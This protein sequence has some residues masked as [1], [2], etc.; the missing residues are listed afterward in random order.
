M[1]KFKPIT[2]ENIN[3]LPIVDGQLIFD[4]SVKKGIYLDVGNTRIKADGLSEVEI[5]EL[6][7]DK[8]NLYHTTVKEP[9]IMSIVDAYN[10]QIDMS[11][12][13]IDLF[14][15]K[16]IG[17]EVPNLSPAYPHI[18]CEFESGMAIGFDGGPP[19][20][21]F[22]RRIGN[23]LNTTPIDMGGE[24]TKLAGVSS[25]APG[26][27]SPISVSKLLL[28]E[29]TGKII[30]IDTESFADGTAPGLNPPVADF[31]MHMAKATVEEEVEKIID[32]E[33]AWIKAN[34]SSTIIKKYTIPYGTF[35]TTKKII[36]DLDLLNPKYLGASL[37]LVGWTESEWGKQTGLDV[38]VQAPMVS[39][40]GTA[41]YLAYTIA[42][43]TDHYMHSG[44]K[45]PFAIEHPALT[46]QGF[47]GVPLSSYDYTRLYGGLQSHSGEDDTELLVVLRS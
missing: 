4:I 15:G 31:S 42:G 10:E 21:M 6:L 33:D 24:S 45:I 3:Q 5:N 46:D 34:E 39:R 17:E 23:G 38:H 35:I 29:N 40:M 44:V 41:G 9:K 14:P 28:P 47:G 20:L 43:I 26:S 13:I 1:A 27:P 37:E 12:L 11:G 16:D 19:Y 18:W 30:Y 22:S 32:V 36:D 2:T 7:E 8:A 25:G